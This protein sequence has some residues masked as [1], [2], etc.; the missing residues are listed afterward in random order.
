MDMMYLDEYIV[1]DGLGRVERG[2]GLVVAGKGDESA[3][4]I[5]LKIDLKSKNFQG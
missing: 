1:H 3:A 2:I 4:R 5:S